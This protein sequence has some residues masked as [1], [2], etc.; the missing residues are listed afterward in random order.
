MEKEVGACAIPGVAAGHCL[1]AP[2]SLGAV[3]GPQQLQRLQMSL[4]F[5]P[6]S[7]SLSE[8][9]ISLVRPFICSHSWK[10]TTRYGERSS[11]L[12]ISS[13]ML[14]SSVIR[15]RSSSRRAL[16]CPPAESYGLAGSCASPPGPCPSPWRGRPPVV[17]QLAASSGSGGHQPGQHLVDYHAHSCMHVHMCTNTHSRTHTYTKHTFTHT[18]THAVRHTIHTH[19]YIY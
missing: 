13:A 11:A 15:S 7:S 8:R 3:G 16:T 10:A 4:T 5:K 19:S 14:N 9:R 6:R 1:V 18:H 17:K 2:G 12:A